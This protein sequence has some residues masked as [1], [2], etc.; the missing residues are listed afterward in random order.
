M[1]IHMQ[2]QELREQEHRKQNVGYINETEKQITGVFPSYET[3]LNALS[4]MQISQKI[5]RLKDKKPNTGIVRHHLKLIEEKLDSVYTSNIDKDFHHDIKVALGEFLNNTIVNAVGKTIIYNV[6]IVNKGINSYIEFRV[7]HVYKHPFTSQDQQNRIDLA[8]KY[9]LLPQQLLEAKTEEERTK[10]ELKITQMTTGRGLYIISQ[11]FD[12]IDEIYHDEKKKMRTQILKKYLFQR[13]AKETTP[14]PFTAMYS[15]PFSEYNNYNLEKV[16]VNKGRECVFDK[17]EIL[18]PKSSPNVLLYFLNRLETE[19]IYINQIFK[20]E[21]FDDGDVA[22]MKGT[23][24]SIANLAAK[25]KLDSTS[26]RLTYGLVQQDGLNYLRFTFHDVR[27]RDYLKYSDLNN[28]LNSN[29]LSKLKSKLHSGDIDER[30]DGF[31]DYQGLAFS[32]L[33][34]IADIFVDCIPV[35]GKKYH[36]NEISLNFCLDK[37]NVGVAAI[38]HIIH[39]DVLPKEIN[40]CLYADKNYLLISADIG[41][42]EKVLKKMKSYNK[43]FEKR[44]FS[45][46]V[47]KNVNKVILIWQSGDEPVGKNYLIRELVDIADA[48]NAHKL[49]EFSEKAH[50]LVL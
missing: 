36:T 21:I 2:L 44:L 49:Y 28:F 26:I 31:F 45:S 39:S 6:Q 18:N 15:L 4:E 13:D 16:F 27:S 11:I 48:V 22:L 43:I 23:L 5:E 33:M 3:L 50:L 47:A 19:I 17:E 12:D 29:Y 7:D 34:T 14:K 25:E 46:F 38:K 30:L 41:N 32:A 40:E 37:A 35:P 20:R 1:E 24:T 9:A 42:K 10:L 8:K